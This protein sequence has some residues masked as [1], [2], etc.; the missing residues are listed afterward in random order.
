M[1]ISIDRIVALSETVEVA[2]E[3]T[4]GYTGFAIAK[5][6]NDTLKAAGLDAEVTAH[7]VYND[8]HSGRIDGVKYASGETMRFDEKTVEMY[9]AKKV[10][11]LL[12]KNTNF[13]Q[14]TTELPEPD[15][16][17]NRQDLDEDAEELDDDVEI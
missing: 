3:S 15:Q 9:A 16:T 11:K 8:A 5:V 6:I 14:E 7:A 1:S 17:E 13:V 2:K 4:D 12:G 10:A